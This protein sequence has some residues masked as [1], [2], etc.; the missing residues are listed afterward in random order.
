MPTEAVKLREWGIEIEC[1]K[2][3]SKE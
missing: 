1:R 3:P 2:S